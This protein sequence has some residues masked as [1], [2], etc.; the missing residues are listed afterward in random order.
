MSFYRIRRDGL[1]FPIAGLPALERL[2]MEGGLEPEEKVFDPE[3]GEWLPAGGLPALKCAFERY[4]EI[5]ELARERPSP[6][7]GHDSGPM[8]PASRASTTP[9][10]PPGSKR[11]ASSSPRAIS[12]PREPLEQSQITD[13]ESEGF[14]S[15]STRSGT[16]VKP[17]E[18]SGTSPAA[19]SPGAAGGS[20]ETQAPAPGD[21]DSECPPGEFSPAP[22]PP[23]PGHPSGSSR[24]LAKNFGQTRGQVI[25]FPG[26][27]QV[28]R[29]HD[30]NATLAP[31]IQEPDSIPSPSVDPALLLAGMGQSTPQPPR[32]SVRISSLSLVLA[33]LLLLLLVTLY[34]VRH[35]ASLVYEK[36]PSTT[37]S[38]TSRSSGSRT[39][40]PSTAASK[41]ATTVE[42]ASGG[43]DVSAS[44]V[45]IYGA[46]EDDLRTRLM[47]GILPV[48]NDEALESALLVELSR[49]RLKVI[50][51]DASVIR[52][53]G[54]H[55]DM[56]Q[57]AGIRI[58]Y[59]GREG[60]LDRELA[61]IGLVTGKYIRHFDLEVPYLD[62]IIQDDSGRRRARKLDPR[63]ASR[64]YLQRISIVDFLTSGGY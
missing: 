29:Q 34:Y 3:A 25:A 35:E 18:D 42:S 27:R 33:P 48:D 44:G 30:G 14:W 6:P 9:S 1:E 7:N 46:M 21:P 26:T 41:P 28:R 61:A 39:I 51:I 40:S 37:S 10:V 16:T 36:L 24:N 55:S 57:E 31:R 50:S 12:P 58:W 63:E 2:I 5:R 59:Q 15:K 54:R 23:S 45:E 53:G 32:P 49:F 60:E 17:S 22:S 43:I 19:N 4:A 20:H 56:P 62:V 64:F 8:P 11:T 52:W 13:D 47:D 38:S